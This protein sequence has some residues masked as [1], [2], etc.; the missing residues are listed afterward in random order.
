MFAE[1]RDRQDCHAKA[2][3][4]KQCLYNAHGNYVANNTNN[5]DFNK[6]KDNMYPAGTIL[7]APN[8]AIGQLLLARIKQAQ[9]PLPPCKLTA[10]VSHQ[11]L[12]RPLIQRIAL[13]SS[14][15]TSTCRVVPRLSHLN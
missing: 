10:P 2:C 15:H 7:H 13:A 1:E 4:R 5:K 8:S 12:P 3:C 9:E 14:L 6:V 11:L